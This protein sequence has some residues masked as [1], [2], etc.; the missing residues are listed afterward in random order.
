MKPSTPSGSNKSTPKNESQ[1]DLPE[2]L[3]PGATS[4]LDVAGDPDFSQ[5]PKLEDIPDMNWH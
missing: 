1:E 5:A 4:E 3:Q 2:F